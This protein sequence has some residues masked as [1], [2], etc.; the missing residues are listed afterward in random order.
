M[1]VSLPGKTM[2]LFGEELLPLC[3]TSIP[4]CWELYFDGGHAEVERILPDLS[5]QITD[6]GKAHRT[7]PGAGRQIRFPGLSV[8]L[9]DR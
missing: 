2:P 5:R 3:A 4:A 9:S 6:P 8:S 1:G 7:A